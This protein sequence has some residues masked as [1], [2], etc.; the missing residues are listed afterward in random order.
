MTNP[1]D[2]ERRAR[3]AGEIR[4]NDSLIPG[5]FARLE[6]LGLSENTLVIFLADHGEHLGEQR[7]WE[8]RPPTLTPVIHVPLMMVYP[9][10]F[11]EPKRIEQNVQLIDVMPTILDLAGIERNDLLL[12]GESLVDLIEGRNTTHWRDRVV[13]AEEPTAMQRGAPCPCAS[14]MYR[15]WHLVASTWMW[16]GRPL[17]SRLPATPQAILQMR[18]YNFH[19]DPIEE[20]MFPSF[21]PDLYLRWLHYDSTTRLREA[22]RIIHAKLTTDEKA[23][24]RLDPETLEHLRGLGYT[25]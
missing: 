7:Y 16:R 20:T 3:Y 1:T 25:N 5:F 2:Q 18:V 15:D 14:L 12:Q 22:G 13:V 9:R 8:H 6:A 17:T 21:W 24:T 10:R 11:T 19:E 23:N 4:H